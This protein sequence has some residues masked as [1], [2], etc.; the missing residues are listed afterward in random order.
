MF[1]ALG[2]NYQ[3]V[4][5]FCAANVATLGSDFGVAVGAEVGGI[6]RA[7]HF[8][9]PYQGEDRLKYQGVNRLEILL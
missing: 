6:S 4:G 7:I 2:K 8:I 1:H 5:Q 3:A 9:H